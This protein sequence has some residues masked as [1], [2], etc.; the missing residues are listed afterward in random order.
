MAEVYHRYIRRGEKTPEPTQ[1]QRDREE[2]NARFA[3][4][5]ARKES[6]LADLREAESK[7]RAGELIEKATATRQASF[8][9]VTIRQRLLA[10]PP[11][12]ARRLDVPDKHQARMIIDSAI[13]EVLTELAELPNVITRGQYEAQ[14]KGRPSMA[15]NPF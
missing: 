12:L 1:E 15:S 3:A 6:A 9:F 7:R 11:L 13:R 8:L 10:L 14:G 5:R 4:A 2:S